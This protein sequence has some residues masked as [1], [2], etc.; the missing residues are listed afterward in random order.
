MLHE[1]YNHVHIAMG[2]KQCVLQLLN[3]VVL[4]LHKRR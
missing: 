1:Y 2:W 3:I 4:K